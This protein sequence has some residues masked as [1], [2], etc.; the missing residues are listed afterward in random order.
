MATARKLFR[1]FK[2]IME[3]QKIVSL[4]NNPPKDQDEIGLVLGNIRF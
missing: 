3:Y 2:W 1:L 4:L